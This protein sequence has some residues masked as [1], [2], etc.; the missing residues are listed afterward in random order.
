MNFGNYDTYIHLNKNKQQRK[1]Q[2]PNPTVTA[3]HDPDPPFHNHNGMPLR[4]YPKL[5][6]KLSY[7]KFALLYRKIEIHNNM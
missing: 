1:N 2:K 5:I 4:L 7:Q 6:R 3:T